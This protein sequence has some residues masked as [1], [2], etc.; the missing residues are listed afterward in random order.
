MDFSQLTALADTS[1]EDGGGG[2]SFLTSLQN[3]GTLFGTAYIAD[4][5]DLTNAERSKDTALAEQQANLNAKV[6]IAGLT[7]QNILIG[8][9]LL[10]AAVVLYKVL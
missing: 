5:F 8:G 10:V 6:Q 7:S 4:K 3:L 9:A 1:V 2:P